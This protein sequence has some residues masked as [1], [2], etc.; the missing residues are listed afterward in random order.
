MSQNSERIERET[1]EKRL[2]ERLEGS[3]KYELGRGVFNDALWQGIK[4]LE[5]DMPQ[6][7][8]GE[9]GR[10]NWGIIVIDDQKWLFL[11]MGFPDRN[12]GFRGWTFALDCNSPQ[13][14]LFLTEMLRTKRVAVDFPNN[15]SQRMD[16]NPADSLVEDHGETLKRIFP[17]MKKRNQ[18]F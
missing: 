15:M 18:A 17:A 9:V 13:T 11:Q 1:A 12:R 8:D 4:I 16:P 5:G 6:I 3:T 14:L 7:D 2:R 10:H